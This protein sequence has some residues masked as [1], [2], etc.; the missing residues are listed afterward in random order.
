MDWEKPSAATAVGAA[1]MVIV[2]GGPGLRMIDVEPV[3]GRQS[4]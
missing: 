1:E 2:A 3:A 4:R